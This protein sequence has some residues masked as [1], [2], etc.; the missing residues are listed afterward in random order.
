MGSL[1]GFNLVANQ[2]PLVETIDL[3]GFMELKIESRL[4]WLVL[5]QQFQVS[6]FKIARLFANLKV[7]IPSVNV[8]E[9][10]ISA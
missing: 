5:I 6:C 8:K 7:S 9:D 2:L 3:N 1:I 4:F 10:L